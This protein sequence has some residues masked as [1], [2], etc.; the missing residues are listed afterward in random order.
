MQPDTIIE[1]IASKDGKF[2][3]MIMTVEEWK[4]KPKKQRI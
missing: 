2:Y 3:K 1:I 4:I